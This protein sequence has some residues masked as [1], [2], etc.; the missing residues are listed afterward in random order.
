[1]RL[2]SSC[3]LLLVLA[4]RLGAAGET[5]A[6]VRVQVGHE[7]D[8][9]AERICTPEPDDPSNQ[10]PP[11]N[12]TRLILEGTLGYSAGRHNLGAKLHGGGKLFY[13]QGTEDMFA[14]NLGGEYRFIASKVVSLGGRLTLNDTSMRDHRRDYLLAHG[15]VFQRTR[16]LS[17]LTFEVYAG[18]RY[19][20]FKPDAYDRY[21][22]KYSHAGPVAGFRFDL[23][24]GAVA[25]SVFYNIKARFIDD[26][27]RNA[28]FKQTQEDRFD[29]RH[30]GGLRVKHPIRYWGQRLLIVEMSYLLSFNDT[31][32][33]GSRLMWHRLKLALSFHLPLSIT[34]H[35]MGTLQFTDYLDGLPVEVGLYEPDADENENSLVVRISVPLWEGLNAVLHGAVYRNAFHSGTTEEISFGRET[36]ML[37]LA[38]DWSN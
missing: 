10:P 32:S 25:S 24:G 1:M 35:L 34:L 21:T 23:G 27:S 19:Y 12:V 38:Y 5:S 13:N 7:Y 9:N 18:G 26:L 6:R 30:T 14:V 36:I 15:E 2:M 4:P 16:L 11:D 31:N 3:A 37:G 17:W 8:T 22:L 20:Y 29:L 33:F 28:S